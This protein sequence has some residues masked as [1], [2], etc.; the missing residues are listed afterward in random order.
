MENLNWDGN[1]D[2]VLNT[3]GSVSSDFMKVIAEK[4]I[5]NLQKT[6]EFLNKPDV[7]TPGRLPRTYRVNI[8]F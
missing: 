8:L 4:I 2:M 6:I 1:D 7:I 3:E 5:L